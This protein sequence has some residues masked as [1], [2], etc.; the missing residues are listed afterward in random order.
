M[1]IMVACRAELKITAQQL[2]VKWHWLSRD[3]QTRNLMHGCWM[4]EG[5]RTSSSYI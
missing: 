1:K 2:L 4:K 5:S 3:P